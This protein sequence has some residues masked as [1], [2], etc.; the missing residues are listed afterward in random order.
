MIEV[1]KNIYRKGRSD[2]NLFISVNWIKTIYFNYKMFPFE[3]AK[4]LPIYFYGSVKFSSLK[5]SVKID[6]PIKRAMIG[7][8]QQ[9]EFP[10]RSKG[11]AELSLNGQLI[12]KSNAHIGLDYAILIAKD[13]YCEF[14]FMGCLGSNVKLICTEKIILGDW[15]GIG[16]NSQLIDTNSHPMMNTETGEHYPLSNA[17]ELGNYNAISNTVTIMPGT[18]TPDHCVIAS[19]TLCNR[20]YT[21]LGNNVLLGGIP[22]KLLKNNFARDWESERGSL[23]KSKRVT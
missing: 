10:T 17:I 15:C 20:D 1:L 8:G 13:A 6:A 14:G 23:L 2:F 22:G 4:K 9:F 12:F 21:N 7:F 18:K 5:G 19:F 3:T 16:Y 11:T